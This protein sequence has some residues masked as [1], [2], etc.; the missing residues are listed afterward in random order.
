LSP[1]EGRGNILHLEETHS[2][3]KCLIL[4]QAT[5][6]DQH[7]RGL[8]HNQSISP[9]FYEQLFRVKVFF[10]TFLYIK[11]GWV[12]FAKKNQNVH[13]AVHKMLAEL[14]PGVDFNNI[15]YG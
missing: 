14:T 9:T 1:G 15:F 12:I 13:I 2:P 11:F 10:L 6:G 3:G 8:I 5:E 7:E 4:C